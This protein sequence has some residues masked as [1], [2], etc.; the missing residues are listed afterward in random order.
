MPSLLHKA[1]GHPEQGSLELSPGVGPCR[2]SPWHYRKKDLKIYAGHHLII[3]EEV[4]SGIASS[5]LSTGFLPGLGFEDIVWEVMEISA[6]HLLFIRA[7]E[8]ELN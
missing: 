5:R 1:Q 2:T 7:F 3:I 8:K 6:A 4:F